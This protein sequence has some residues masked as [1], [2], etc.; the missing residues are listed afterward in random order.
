MVVFLVSEGHTYTLQ[1]VK[2][3]ARVSGTRVLVSNYETLFQSKRTV[4]A[5]YVFTDMD[6]LSLPHLQ[7]ACT[8]YR[9]LRDEGLRVLNDPARVPSRF[10]LLRGLHA[11]GINRFNAYRVEEGV[12]PQRW[13]VFLRAEG[14]HGKP[15]S[16]L[17]H[18]WE[19][20]QREIDAAIAAGAPLPS[21]L[22]VEY[23]AEPVRPGL[24]RK[25]GSFRIGT[26]EFAHTCVHDDTWLVKYGKKGIAGEDLY[27]EELRIVRENPYREALSKVFSLAA[28]EY[29]RVDFGMV[30]GE[31]QVYEINSN[32][33]MKFPLEHPFPDRVESYRTF[34]ANYMAA[35][36]GIDSPEEDGH[37]EISAPAAKP[38]QPARE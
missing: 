16:G 4:R 14:A 28:I 19:D 7:K 32:P 22:I 37:V 17:L 38:E 9:R 3:R 25:F 23:A 5:T 35:L 33:D 6:R 36:R 20:V 31:V 12:R 34:E 10:G 27:R 2:E 1:K 24:Y 29:G 8:Y 13:P 21:L 18:T 30:G 15:L 26:A 11:A